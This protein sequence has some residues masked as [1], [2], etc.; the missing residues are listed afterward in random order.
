MSAA[1]LAGWPNDATEI[2]ADLDMPVH[3]QPQAVCL[4]AIIDELTTPECL[5]HG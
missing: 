4:M 5:A 3:T 2:Q 1:T